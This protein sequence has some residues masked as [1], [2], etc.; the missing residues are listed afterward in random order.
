MQF[1]TTFIVLA[2]V[3]LM[4]AGYLAYQHYFKKTPLVCPIGDDCHTVVES[5]WGNIFG[6]RNEALGVLYYFTV[7]IGGVALAAAPTTYHANLGMLLVFETGIGVLFSLFLT[8][9]QAFSIKSY[10]FYC[11]MSALIALLLFLNSFAV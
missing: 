3:G 11:L 7:L 10:C 9:V 6:V 1:L 5:R 4:D 2:A 8:G